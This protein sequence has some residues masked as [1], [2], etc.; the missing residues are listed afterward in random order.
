M[1]QSVIDWSM[2]ESLDRT[3]IWRNRRALLLCVQYSVRAV[4]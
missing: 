4:L 1:R 3:E 2:K